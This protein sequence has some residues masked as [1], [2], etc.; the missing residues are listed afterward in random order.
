MCNH[1]K[2]KC[3]KDIIVMDFHKKKKK[4]DQFV[5]RFFFFYNLKL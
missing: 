5:S 2:K 3:M 4:N 1:L